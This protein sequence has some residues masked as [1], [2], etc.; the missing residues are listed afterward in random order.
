M[1]FINDILT[2]CTFDEEYKC[3]HT[4]ILEALQENHLYVNLVQWSKRP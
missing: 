1:F 2:Y 3:H 4:L